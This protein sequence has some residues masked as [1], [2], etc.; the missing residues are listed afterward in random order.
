VFLQFGIF[1]MLPFCELMLTEPIL[2]RLNPAK[3]NSF[4]FFSP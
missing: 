1:P 3:G 4:A 2:C